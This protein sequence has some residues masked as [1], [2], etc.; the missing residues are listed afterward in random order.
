MT[1]KEWRILLKNLRASFPV[2]APVTIRKRP[3][4]DCAA[5]IFDGAHYRIT[6]NADQPDVGLID[7][8]LHEWAHVKTIEEAYR[9]GG[10][11]AENFG[12]IYQA[13]CDGFK[14]EQR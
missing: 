1:T 13:W 2:E 3:K 6:I 8:I 9:H 4:I 5:T 10:R 11:W 12:E 7:S 14:N